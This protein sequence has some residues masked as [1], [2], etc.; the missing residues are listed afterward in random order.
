MATEDQKSLSGGTESEPPNAPTAIANYWSRITYRWGRICA[1][2]RR[3]RGWIGKQRRKAQENV[4]W[5][6]SAVA[7]AAIWAFVAVFASSAKVQSLADPGKSLEFLAFLRSAWWQIGIIV[8][9]PVLNNIWKRIDKCLTPF[10]AADRLKIEEILAENRRETVHELAH[11][12]RKTKDLGEFLE[13]TGHIVTQH[14][15]DAFAAILDNKRK[16]LKVTTYRVVEGEITEIWAV[17]PVDA[18][19]RSRIEVIRDNRS[20]AMRCMRSGEI[21]VIEDLEVEAKSPKPRFLPDPQ[22][23]VKPTGSLICFPVRDR[24]TKRT[25]AIICI[26]N[27]RPKTFDESQADF[28]ERELETYCAEI[29]E[30]VILASRGYVLPSPLP[31]TQGRSGG[32]ARAR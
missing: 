16:G 2:G 18:K 23:P 13:D 21:L 25:Y 27:Q 3:L 10:T 12:L 24:R 15:R 9:G 32:E 20:A 17:G 6:V 22:N 4:W 28:Y 7:L 26:Q 8:G 11:E 19:T 30:A 1:A 5:Q 31:P 14:L 29:L